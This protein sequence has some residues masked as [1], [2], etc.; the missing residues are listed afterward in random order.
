[1]NRANDKHYNTLNQGRN[2]PFKFNNFTSGIPF[3][4]VSSEIITYIF[5]EA[6]QLP[7]WYKPDRI[8]IF[9]G[10]LLHSDYND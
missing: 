7:V 8:C 9:Q 10:V 2:L 1:M 5:K 6:P 4:N 3:V